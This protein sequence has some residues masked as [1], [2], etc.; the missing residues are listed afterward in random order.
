MRSVKRR[1]DPRKEELALERIEPDLVSA[2]DA[3]K[4]VGKMTW[5]LD[6]H[7]ASTPALSEGDRV[8]MPPIGKHT[9][10]GGYARG[11]RGRD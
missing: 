8:S 5:E 2:I 4:S 7:P 6:E 11:S 9:E 10:L 3:M 1:V